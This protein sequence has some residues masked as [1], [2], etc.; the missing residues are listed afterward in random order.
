MELKF[1][2]AN[3]NV[4][5]KI[6]DAVDIE[7]SLSTYFYQLFIATDTL[8][9]SATGTEPMYTIP[10][11]NDKSKIVQQPL[12]FRVQVVD[13][14]LIA[15]IAKVSARVSFLYEAATSSV[16]LESQQMA[17]TFTLVNLNDDSSTT[18]L[19]ES[20]FLSFTS[21]PSAVTMAFSS[22]EKGDS[23]SSIVLKDDYRNNGDNYTSK[24]VALIVV[25]VFLSIVLLIVSSVLLHITGGWKA[26]TNTLSNCL[27]EE[28][29][30]DDEDDYYNN[31]NDASKQVE[32]KQYQ[33][34][35]NRQP[36]RTFPLQNSHDQED[37]RDVNETGMNVQEEDDEEEDTNVMDVESAMTSVLPT[38]AS[39]LLGVSRNKDAVPI[40]TMLDDDDDETNMYGDGMTPVSR[41]E[42]E[43]LGIT[44]MRKLQPSTENNK[45]TKNGG[46]FSSGIMMIQNRLLRSASKKDKAVTPS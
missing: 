6:E 12:Q 29:D 22:N 19:K 40:H 7:T 10:M 1:P 23:S 38:S 42:N 39:G 31:N 28:V 17:E 14:I 15:N 46:G 30:D 25:T 37:D 27:F 13:S 11:E 20:L 8:D 36:S 41:S 32:Q 4:V 9:N 43:P 2:T 3:N 5:V 35:I 33:Q 16:V 18:A 34:Y 24:E 44:S 26:F 21:N 45:H